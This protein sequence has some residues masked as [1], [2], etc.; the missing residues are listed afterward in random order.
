MKWPWRKSEAPEI[1]W[2]HVNEVIGVRLKGWQS[3]FGPMFDGLAKAAKITR[4][5]AILDVLVVYEQGRWDAAERAIH[6]AFREDC[7]HCQNQR[8]AAEYMKKTMKIMEQESKDIDT[9]EGWRKPE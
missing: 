3:D 2:N 9:D 4:V 8:A 6:P 5:E 7:E 1:D